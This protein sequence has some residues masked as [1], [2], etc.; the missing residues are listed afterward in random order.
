MGRKKKISDLEL[1]FLAGQNLTHQEMA[2]LLDVSRSTITARMASLEK[3]SPELLRISDI[4]TFRKEETDRIA[5]LRQLML[6]AVEHKLK[7]TVVSQESLVTLMKAYGILFDKDRLLRGEATEHVAHASYQQL[8]DKT[9]KV[10][11]DAVK[12]LTS[13]ML[14]EARKEHDDVSD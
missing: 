3:K 10:I 7:N 6:N 14:D 1:A 4:N 2:D 9:R 12:Q 5:G 11:G 8:D 13:N